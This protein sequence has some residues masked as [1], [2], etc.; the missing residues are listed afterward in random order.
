MSRRLFALAPVAALAVAACGSV[1]PGGGSGTGAPATNPKTVVLD[2]AHLSTTTSFRADFSVGLTF[3]ATGTFAGEF[4]ALNGEAIHLSLHIEEQSK[5]RLRVDVTT[6]LGSRAARASVLDYDGTLYKSVNGGRFRRLP[7]GAPQ[8]SQF[9]PSN[10]LQYLQSVGTVADTGAGSVDG[11][12]VEE[13]RADL[14]PAK[15]AS[16]LTKA[17]GSLDNPL[18]SSVGKALHF[19]DGYL[20]IALDSSNRLVQEDGVVDAS[21]DLSSLAPGLKGTTMSFAETVSAH[22]YDYGAA[23]TVSRPPAASTGV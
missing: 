6:A 14:D 15:V 12:S 3:N 13:Y 4:S 5:T 1:A 11:V 9:G 8:G 17:L 19:Q 22:F 10:A 2:A 18:L 20:N 23:I 16:V 21:L 7:V